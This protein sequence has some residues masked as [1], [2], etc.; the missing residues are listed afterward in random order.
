MPLGG[1]AILHSCGIPVGRNLTR[2]EHRTP[3]CFGTS[4]HGYKAP[5]QKSYEM[6]L[7]A[8]HAGGHCL[9]GDHTRRSLLITM[10]E[11]GVT[12][13]ILQMKK[14]RHTA[15]LRSWKPVSG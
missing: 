5:T 10:G 7:T 13:P 4:L 14:R 15:R 12:A 9:A 2:T 3:A 11:V 8:D 1:A 6:Q